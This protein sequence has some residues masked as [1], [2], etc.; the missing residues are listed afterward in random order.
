MDGVAVYRSPEGSCVVYQ[1]ESCAACRAA[2]QIVNV[3]LSD[4]FGCCSGEQGT[5]PPRIHLSH[6]PCWYLRD[7][8]T[9]VNHTRQMHL[10]ISEENLW[11]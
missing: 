2:L 3:N 7:D 11:L 6:L 4:E 9:P 10:I 5:A 8:E 1:A